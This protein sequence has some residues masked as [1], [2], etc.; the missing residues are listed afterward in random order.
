MPVR[1]LLDGCLWPYARK[2]HYSAGRP[3]GSWCSNGDRAVRRLLPI[4]VEYGRGDSPR[5]PQRMSMTKLLF[6]KASPRGAQSK[7]TQVA[8]AYL[9]ALQVATPALEV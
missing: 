3:C 9:K 1:G 4:S 8:E 2:D 5:C 7:S 6:I